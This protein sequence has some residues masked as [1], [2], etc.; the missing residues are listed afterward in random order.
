MRLNTSWFPQ[1]H[2]CTSA[3]A[4]LEVLSPKAGAYAVDSAIFS[5][6][7]GLKARESVLVHVVPV[8]G[9]AY[10]SLP[11]AMGR[12]DGSQERGVY[13]LG[14]FHGVPDQGFEQYVLYWDA[15]NGAALLVPFASWWR[16]GLD[17]WQAVMG[18]QPDSAAPLRPR[19]YWTQFDD[20]LAG[21]RAEVRL[22]VAW[23]LRAVA[24]VTSAE[25]LM[26]VALSENSRIPA[27]VLKGYW[28]VQGMPAR[29]APGVAS[30]STALI[31]GESDPQAS[32][33]KLAYTVAAP[34]GV[35]MA[36]QCANVGAADWDL[37]HQ[38]KAAALTWEACP[39]LGQAGSW[40]GAL[41][42]LSLRL[43]SGG[44][45]D[46]WPAWGS[47]SDAL[48]LP[49]AERATNLLAFFEKYHN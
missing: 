34:L 20:A 29:A 47:V 33:S 16:A 7:L 15:H 12:A 39:E 46:E 28:Q 45:T 32:Q 41:T 38:T 24:R 35:A 11:L 14:W 37:R 10:A 40:P 4:V 2:A 25:H 30:L 36:A 22:P 31:M 26:L 49:D 3:R 1:G 13:D 21:W 27:E 44:S 9:L 19:F 8:A 5:G 43:A 42:N 48:S 23:W 18:A 17:L 6:L